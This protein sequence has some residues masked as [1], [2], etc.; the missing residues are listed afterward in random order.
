VIRYDLLSYDCESLTVPGA[1][2][3]V[4][5]PDGAGKTTLV[6]R[7]VARIIPMGLEVVEVREPGGTPVAEIARGAAL[8]PELD[9]APLAELFLMLAARAD[10]VA[11]VIRPA[12]EAGKVVV[13][14]RFD[15]S[16]Q[17]Y[18][19]A[20]RG[21]PAE[22]VLRANHLA[23]GGLRPDFTLVLDLPGAVGLSRQAADGKRADRMEREAHSWHER[24]AE[25]FAGAGGDGV[26]H[27]DAEQPADAVE[28]DAWRIVSGRLAEALD[29]GTG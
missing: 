10:L 4:E 24:V 14:D 23:T 9:A 28:R 6:K 19:I 17:A 18:Q 27:L 1:F 25:A 3:V 22:P 15:L 13:S 26:V 16:T 8:D 7:L 21:L 12:L 29:L 20:G 11:K 5:G 2:I